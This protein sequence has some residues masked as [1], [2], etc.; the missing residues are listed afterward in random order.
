MYL[1]LDLG[2]SSLKVL[3][4]GADGHVVGQA[5]APLEVS[6]PHPRWSE[7]APAA[8]WQALT[9]AMAA[10]RREHG[11]ALRTVQ[12]IGLSGQMHGATLLDERD[13]VLRPA[14]LWDDGR[15]AAQCDEL[16]RRAPDLWRI[17]GNLAMPGFTA[18]KLLWVREHEPEIFA[19]VRKVLLPKDWLRWRLT[20][21]YFS[22]MSDAAGTLWLDVGRRDWSDEMLAACDLTR[23][24]MPAVVEGSAPAGRLRDDVADALGLPRG[25]VVAGGGGDN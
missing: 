9:E 12:G 10:L 23:D 22:D 4:L 19:R 21:E 15:S 25:V 6:R 13:E 8:W 24:H 14:I 11:Q 16:M 20:G 1:G 17:T 2:T 18:P 3:L 7:Q 5:A